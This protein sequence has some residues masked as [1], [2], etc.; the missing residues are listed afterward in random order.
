MKSVASL[1]RLL[2]PHVRAAV[3]RAPVTYGVALAVPG[4][5]LPL[6]ARFGAFLEVALGRVVVGEIP[7]LILVGAAHRREAFAVC[8]TL[9]ER[10]K[11]E[12]PLFG[13]ELTSGP[14]YRWK[15]NR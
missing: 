12:V 4:A 1:R 15:Q 5:V 7:L 2:R 9:L 13:K 6:L 8:E 3:E 14:G 11:T 10:L